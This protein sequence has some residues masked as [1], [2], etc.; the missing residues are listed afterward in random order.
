MNTNMSSNEASGIAG[1]MMNFTKIAILLASAFLVVLVV[2]MGIEILGTFQV[3]VLDTT[4]SQ[5]ETSNGK[6]R[7][8]YYVVPVFGSGTFG[9]PKLRVTDVSQAGTSINKDLDPVS[10]DRKKPHLYLFEHE[11]KEEG[12]HELRYYVILGKDKG[13][14]ERSRDHKTTVN[15][16]IPKHC[17]DCP[18]RC[19]ECPAPRDYDMYIV[20]KQWN[21][22]PSDLRRSTVDFEI[23]LRST[24]TKQQLKDRIGWNELD[25]PKD[26]K[27]QD[28]TI[29]CRGRYRAGDTGEFSL[30]ILGVENLRPICSMGSYIGLGYPR[31]KFDRCPDV[32]AGYQVWGF[33]LSTYIID[34]DGVELLNRDDDTQRKGIRPK[35]KHFGYTLEEQ[36]STFQLIV[37]GQPRTIAYQYPY[38][39]YPAKG[40]R[41]YLV[42]KS[43][44]PLDSLPRVQK[45]LPDTYETFGVRARDPE[46][47]ESEPIIPIRIYYTGF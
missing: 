5:I 44:E 45:Q 22:L 2:G 40:G 36:P 33:E 14:V 35:A 39:V 12:S 20:E 28:P 10:P 17:K 19:D 26:W 38:K 8:F 32:P 47:R 42:R 25:W 46:G 24:W 6:V 27:P 29:V 13:A 21:F 16:S 18:P 43:G 7:L 37:Q 9:K 4:D 3:V 23:T 34:P 30:R 15:Y 31:N 41:W 11:V 1:L